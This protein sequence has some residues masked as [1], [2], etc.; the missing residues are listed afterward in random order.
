MAKLL[1][2]VIDRL[3]KVEHNIE[4]IELGVYGDS[5]NEIK[6]LIQNVHEL[7]KDVQ[8]LQNQIDNQKI[9]LNDKWKKIGYFSS[10]ALA[11]ITIIWAII[12]WIS[13]L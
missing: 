4:T 3:K 5:K 11:V 6:G 12:K 2:D 7:Q 9:I 8:K 10:G 1:Q 13:T